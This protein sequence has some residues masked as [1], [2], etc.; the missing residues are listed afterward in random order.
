[1]WKMFLPSHHLPQI[2]FLPHLV[3]MELPMMLDV[4]EE[5]RENT[6]FNSPLIILAIDAP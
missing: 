1:M 5:V 3:H 2:L 6:L 4:G